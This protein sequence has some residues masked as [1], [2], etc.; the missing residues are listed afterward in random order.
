MTPWKEI[1]GHSESNE[2]TS[3]PQGARSWIR[4]LLTINKL[5]TKIPANFLFGLQLKEM[6]FSSRITAF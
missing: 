2:P 3:D 5:K 4:S 6:K 1:R